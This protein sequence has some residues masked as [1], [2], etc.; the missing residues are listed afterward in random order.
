MSSRFLEIPLATQR[1]KFPRP[2]LPAESPSRG[3]ESPPPEPT[4]AQRPPT[5]RL[6][7]H[8]EPP[9]VPSPVIQAP[10]NPTPTLFQQPQTHPM[11]HVP[12]PQQPL[13]ASVSQPAVPVPP[14][15]PSH[16]ASAASPIQPFAQQSMSQQQGLATPHLQQQHPPSQSQV[17]SQYA[18]HGLP[19][20]IDPTQNQTPHAPQHIPSSSQ[21]QQNANAHSTYFR[22]AEAPY[23][24]T[25]TPPAGQ[26][27][28]SPYG[29]FGP[30]GQQGQHQAQAQHLGGF[31]GG[32]YGY[33]DNQ[34]VSP[35]LFSGDVDRLFHRAFTSP[36]LNS[37]VL[38][39]G[40]FWVTM[41]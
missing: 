3:T 6:Q 12:H 41:T 23:F 11:P 39:I 21:P 16:A 37:L 19:T 31:G 4:Q 14:Q 33:G 7:A 25:P 20:H 35:Y 38:V 22:Q 9:L 15:A 10:H 24:H 1:S 5:P 30:L 18:Q 17:H 26:V 34:R 32:E 8:S 28:D 40:M 29:A 2:E 27:Q 36:M 13:Q